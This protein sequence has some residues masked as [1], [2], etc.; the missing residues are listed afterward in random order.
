VSYA[1]FQFVVIAA[2]VVWSV[3]FCARRFFPRSVR[4]V[5]AGFAHRLAASP[6]ATIRSIGVKYTPQQVAS[7]AGCGSGG[8]CSSC[9]TCAP[10]ASVQSDVRPLV[11]QP[12]VK[13]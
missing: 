9:G 10:T 3:W 13:S 5:Q 1:V 2:I 6:N 8:G 12:R 4:A 7:G 11:F